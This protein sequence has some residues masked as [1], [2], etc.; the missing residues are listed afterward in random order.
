V[1]APWSFYGRREEL[2]SLPKI[3]WD[4]STVF[5][6][7]RAHG[8]ADPARS[9]TLY[10]LFGGVPKYWR[11]FNAVTNDLRLVEETSDL[12]E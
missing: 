12:R 1:T 3:M 8:A 4:L 5:E 9:L 2:G 7:C 6:V 10:T 11:H